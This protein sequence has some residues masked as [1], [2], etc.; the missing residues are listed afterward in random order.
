M[1]GSAGRGEGGAEAKMKNME[2]AYLRLQGEWGALQTHWQAA[3]EEW[4]DPAGNRFE[5]GF[6]D[7]WEKEVPLALLA[8][9]ELVQVL[10][11]ALQN[12]DVQK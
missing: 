1:A 6:W 11:Q 5:H 9:S 12:T 2:E 10:A 8:I 3:Q 7:E 4:H